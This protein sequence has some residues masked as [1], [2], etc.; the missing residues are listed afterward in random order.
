MMSIKQLIAEAHRRSVWKVLGVYVAVSWGIYQIIKEITDLFG[1]PDWVPGFAIVLFLIGLPI[2]LATAV[3]QEGGPASKPEPETT[4]G[5]RHDVFTW[6]KAVLGGICAFL[7][8]GITAGGYMGM[9][10]A[11][12]GP[13]G[14]L[15]ASG[16]LGEREPILV[17]EFSAINA[18]TMLASAVTEAFRLD[19]AQSASIS[20]VEPAHVRNVLKRMSRE[21]DARV[22][23][24]LA[25]EISVRDNIKAYITG[26]VSRAGSKYIIAAKL[27][28]TTDRRVLT[29]HKE[30]A[31][32]EDEIIGAVDKLSKKLRGRIGDSFK[33]IRAERP[34]EAVSTPSLEA[35]H[36]Y[37]QAINALDMHMDF[38]NGASLLG[39]A[40]ELDSTFAM[41]W[42]KLATV[43][44]NTL[45]GRELQVFAASKAYQYRDRLPDAERYKALAYYHSTVTEDW[46]KTINAYRMLEERDP[47]YAPNNLGIAYM[48]IRE[49]EKADSALR[50]AMKKDSLLSNPYL[51]LPQ[52]LFNQGK[53]A[54]AYEI[55]DEG[56][57]RFADKP[58]FDFVRAT[59]AGSSGQYERALELTRKRLASTR[60]DVFSQGMFLWL[61]VRLQST[62]GR[63]AASENALEALEANEIARGAG[64]QAL[65]LA[66]FNVWRDF[67]TRRDPRRALAR[68][69][70]A[71]RTY[72]IEKLPVLD[73]PYLAIAAA[74]AILGE[75]D[76]ARSYV[77]AF[78]RV[79]NPE[80]RG[81]TKADYAII[82]GGIALDAKQFD[83]AI[84]EWR[85][86]SEIGSCTICM[87]N[88]LAL[89]FEEA[90]MPDSA[91]ARYRHYVDTRES[92]RLDEDALFLGPAYERL[93][94]LYAARGEVQNA[95]LYAGKFVELWKDADAELQPRVRAK[96]ELLRQLGRR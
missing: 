51:L 64:Y 70:A 50:R 82:Q 4:L 39:E 23:A 67:A 59:L 34:L 24:E 8:L 54:E 44:S 72:P 91:I 60:S 45:R 18:D 15:V 35:L 68:L 7:L 52:I 20:V 41:A 85:S 74:Y 6:Q 36:K 84:A 37:T 62:R 89:L 29:L 78:E 30:T 32:G 17:A 33:V 28:A 48:E 10:N 69:D 94:D 11:G 65:E 49:L 76:R 58:A 93:A 77:A 66:L 2:V 46:G 83:R 3:I 55:L 25:H 16:A 5:K 31:A 57:R 92:Y 1:L 86:A 22:D 47:T 38:E 12:V 40:I 42:R 80:L 63:L 75:V 95:S 61:D 53:T 43:Y 88:E 73:R 26:E 71:V 21:E 14:S 9:R 56:E 96:Q 19:F 27:I 87:D 79:V 13:F 81:N 90:G